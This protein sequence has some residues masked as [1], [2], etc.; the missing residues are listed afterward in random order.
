[1]TKPSIH[2]SGTNESPIAINKTSAAP[3]PPHKPEFK[4]HPFVRR[5][6]FKLA[7]FH[8]TVFALLLTFFAGF[9]VALDSIVTT[10]LRDC[11][12]GATGTN[13]FTALPDVLSLFSIALFMGLGFVLAV[14]TRPFWFFT[15]AVSGSLLIL[16][17]GMNLSVDHESIPWPF[18]LAGFL[19]AAIYT[20]RVKNHYELI[21]GAKIRA[22]FA[23]QIP[24]SQLKKL[25][26]F[27]FPFSRSPANRLVTLMRVGYGDFANAAETL[28]PEQAYIELQ[29]LTKL[30]KGTVHKFGGSVASLDS[31]AVLAFFGYSL[32][33]KEQTDFRVDEALNCA[34]EILQ[35]SL[36]DSLAAAQGG[37]VFCP[38]RVTL[39]TTSVFFG[40]LGDEES[41]NLILMGPGVGLTE[42]LE[43]SCDEFRVLMTATSRD[44][45]RT[46]DPS[47]VSI[48]RR[49]LQIRHHRELIEAYDAD[50]FV[51]DAES[52]SKV[53]GQYR[54]I[55][56]IQRKEPRWP[57]P[58]DSPVRVGS[59]FGS[60]A[61]VNFSLSG[62]GV[63]MDVY[64]AR[65]VEVSV[66]L[67]SENGKLQ[68]SL[69]QKGVS[70]IA[71]EVRWAKQV[72][73]AF[74]HGLRLKN[75][76]SEQRVSVMNALRDHV[77]GKEFEG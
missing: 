36:K 38:L 13:C 57:I 29:R 6:R 62:L 50:P 68:S 15:G 72:G 42:Q 52:I 69:N 14:F 1:M 22:S 17:C 67:E 46:F 8:A 77:R 24:N 32:D 11:W 27:P 45:I 66:Q 40:D 34:I 28:S 61:L 10:T 51:K 23:N 30:I 37:K 20:F 43:E 70:N 54:E 44:L 75:L 25:L 19:A 64:L 35:T 5:Q 2:A 7:A 31:S 4:L 71:A 76:T 21:A 55:V 60:G 63:K 41:W 39:N 65:G 58:V 26:R 74:V 9:G 33:G 12:H 3:T 53:L 49:F 16:V 47:S 59:D 18:V 48:S 56:S 73:N